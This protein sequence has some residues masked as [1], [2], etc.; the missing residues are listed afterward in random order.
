M[1]E[2]EPSISQ[3]T[4]TCRQELDELS[5][6]HRDAIRRTGNDA[7]AE[8]PTA[9]DLLAWV[10][11]Q[12]TKLNLFA[13]VLG[14]FAS[15]S[16]SVEHRLR[17]NSA[18]RSSIAQ[19]LQAISKNL[20]LCIRSRG[21]LVEH[22]RTT[23]DDP[24]EPAPAHDVTKLACRRIGRDCANLVRFAALIRLRSM[25]QYRE[26][27]ENHEPLD[28]DGVP[29]GDYF[30]KVVN[31]A[32]KETFEDTEMAGLRDG[33]SQ[34]IQVN[35]SQRMKQTVISRWKRI[36]YHIARYHQLRGSDSPVEGNVDDE[37][38]VMGDVPLDTDPR[39]AVPQRGDRV[40]APKN[41]VVPQHKKATTFQGSLNEQVKVPQPQSITPSV[42]LTNVAGFSVRMPKLRK[43]DVTYENGML[44]FLCPLC[45]IPQQLPSD[46]SAVHQ[47]R[48]WE[49]HAFYDLEPYVCLLSCKTPETTYRTFEDWTRHTN[50]DHARYTWQCQNCAQSCDDQAAFEHHLQDEHEAKLTAGELAFVAKTCERPV[51]AFSACFI[52]GKYELS[53]QPEAETKEAAAVRERKMMQCMAQHMR[54]MALTSLPDQLSVSDGSAE[55]AARVSDAS[56]ASAPFRTVTQSNAKSTD[57]SSEAF[58]SILSRLKVQ[59]GVTD[60]RAE[61]TNEWRLKSDLMSSDNRPADLPQ[62]ML[63]PETLSQQ[64]WVSTRDL[65][66]VGEGPPQY[67]GMPLTFDHN[68]SLSEADTMMSSYWSVPEQ[69][70]FVKYIAHFGT[71]FAAI[72]NY[73]GTK[74]QVM[75]K[76]HFQRQVDGGRA[77]LAMAARQADQSRARGEDMGPPPIP[78]AGLKRKYD[79]PETRA[80]HGSP[81]QTL[82][83]P[84]DADHPKP[85]LETTLKSTDGG[86]GVLPGIE[87]DGYLSHEID[88]LG[89]SK[90]SRWDRVPSDVQDENRFAS[91]TYHGPPQHK[92]Q[93]DVDVHAAQRRQLAKRESLIKRYFSSGLVPE[94]TGLAKNA[95]HFSADVGAIANYVVPEAQV[96]RPES[97]GKY[98]GIRDIP[99]EGTF[100]IYEG[101]LRIPTH[102]DGGQVNPA[103][104][105]TKADEP[106]KRRGHPFSA[107][108]PISAVERQYETPQTSTPPPDSTVMTSAKAESSRDPKQPHA[109]GLPAKRDQKQVAFRLI[110]QKDPRI[111]SQMPMRVMIS[112]ND[113]TE[114]I[115]TT[116]KNFYGLYNC[117]VSF[118][119]EE[120]FSIIPAADNFDNNMTIYV[121]KMAPSPGPT[122]GHA[123]DLAH[124]RP[125]S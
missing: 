92:R 113:S 76:N 41:L 118:E 64:Y 54:S 73:M 58:E 99:G 32:L 16:L 107:P 116:V 26:R 6:S 95:E 125:R 91:Q 9:F 71:D 19:L 50:N 22:Q 49:K 112:P 121:Q 100:H 97:S 42:A 61:F 24:I 27:S 37:D 2:P 102:V 47:H 83:M 14:V 48:A 13:D 70:D 89:E 17:N 53:G 75:V 62:L 23:D 105:L 117:G 96:I 109:R 44:E 77:D 120:G 94:N 30:D 4:K 88:P 59:Y 46:R 28:N 103:W 36:S 82:P 114:S 7:L 1:A 85:A 119:N 57:P 68:E 79:A 21:Q 63:D 80:S 39:P 60:G 10:P 69:T 84:L 38:I 98:L 35:V 12:K 11:E 104:E 110:E 124:S 25:Q 20:G 66:Y 43:Q 8:P 29:L 123:R 115:I 34:D 5:S 15:G 67:D 87:D 65:D 101:G 78:T 52:C 122:G 55:S 45:K 93:D 108:T 40:S 18:V 51:A 31:R 81:S 72:A 106:R 74:S 90:V 3:L 56:E 33:P 86:T 111:H